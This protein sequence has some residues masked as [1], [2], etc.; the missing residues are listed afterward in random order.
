M[1]FRSHGGIVK[2][3][4]SLVELIYTLFPSSIDH[5]KPESASSPG[6]APILF[7][8]PVDDEA[9]FVSYLLDGKWVTF[10][11]YAINDVT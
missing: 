2:Y 9:S 1:N 4:A 10:H 7:F 5:M 11:R 6:K 3:A 8:S